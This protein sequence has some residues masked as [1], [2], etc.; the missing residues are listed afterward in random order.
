MKKLLGVFL[1]IVMMLSLAA[2]SFNI[3]TSAKKEDFKDLFPDKA[4]QNEKIYKHSDLIYDF[5]LGDYGKMKIA[6]DTSD[7]HKFELQSENGGFNILDKDGNVV[8]YAACT[9]ADKYAELTTYITDT[10]TVNG[11]TFFYSKNGDGS[12]D[13]FSYMADCGLDA[14]LVMEVRENEDAFSLVAFRGEPIEG[15]STNMYDYKGEAPLAHEDEVADDYVYEDEEPTEEP[16]EENSLELDNSKVDT[17]GRVSTLLPETEELLSK[18]DTDYNK[19]NWGVTYSM[20]EELPNFVI[21]VTPYMRYGEYYLLIGMTNLY[22]EPMDF[23]ASAVAYDADGNEI[24]DTFIYIN[25]IG[26]ANTALSLIPCGDK[27]PDGRIHWEEAE[28]KESS[29]SK[30]IPW[31]LDYSLT[32][33][34]SDGVLTASYGIY[35]ANKDTLSDVNLFCV[36]TDENGYVLSLG[37]DYLLEDVPAGETY[38]GEIKIYE[39]EAVLSAVK[40]IA[41]FANPSSYE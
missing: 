8:L 29:F 17:S 13:I 19:I 6:V 1:S 21:S 30:Y 4:S 34:A 39:D 37:S 25:A 16:L 36:L 35:S 5:S 20:F 10:K 11:R 7:G 24:G 27:M 28:L 18:L 26:G 32:G 22:K 38:E 41:F 3:G 40:G 9:P 14:G 12:A 15:K 23:T 33:K 2:C 31:E